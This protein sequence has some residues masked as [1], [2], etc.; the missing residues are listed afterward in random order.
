MATIGVNC[1]H[2]ISGYGTGAVGRIK[3]GEHTRLVGNEVIRL[4]RERGHNVV[5][6]TVDYAGST[7]ESLSK[8]VNMANDVCL[9]WFISV[10]FNAG[11]GKGVEC[12]TYEG[13]QY[14]D[15]IDVCQNI[16]KLGFNNRGVKAGTGL[17]VVRK[18]RAKSM[19]I[20]VCFV[21]STDADKYLQV[22]Y[23]NIAKAIV[24]ALVGYVATPTVP[25][26]IP[27]LDKAAV[28]QQIYNVTCSLNNYAA[29]IQ[30]NSNALDN[31]KALQG[32]VDYLNTHN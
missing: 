31:I 22:G 10:H 3:E 25:K 6:C 13:R 17:Y 2:T 9:D 32:I 5:N 7:S 11:G 18:T 8:V 30:D 19:L 28:I 20:E 4:L 1:G 16:A 23:K 24:D 29:T 21:D 12:Y 15:A 14:R 27:K 26:P